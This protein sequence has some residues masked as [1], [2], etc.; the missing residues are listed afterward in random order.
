M[1]FFERIDRGIA[2]MRTSWA[3]LRT[4]RSLLVFPLVSGTCL[5]LV[6]L[7]FFVP[8]A[9]MGVLASSTPGTLREAAMP[10]LYLGAFAFYVVQYFIITFFQTGLA[11]CAL[12]V[13]RGETVTVRD[14]MAAAG[15]KA[16][17][18]LGYALI[19][20]TVGMLLRVLS[21]RMGLIGRIVIGL[22]GVAW[23]L[24][25]ALVVPVLAAEYVGGFQAISR[26]TALIRSTWG[27]DMVGNAGIGFVCFLAMAVV[28]LLGGFLA[29]HGF[30]HHMAGLG[31]MFLVLTVLGLLAVGLV[32]SSLQGVFVA[33]LY[34][35]AA[36]GEAGDGFTANVLDNAFLPRT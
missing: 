2:L 34:R 1:G 5:L 36:D 3:V 16:L 31:A 26:S 28:G 12:A 22:I 11:F 32:Q 29:Y 4:H 35:Y 15:A 17:P 23:S 20:A 30:T 9:G 24:A 10:G 18:I 21:E 14:G 13:L 19:A 6:S 33:A 7:S 8:L 25:V 27:E